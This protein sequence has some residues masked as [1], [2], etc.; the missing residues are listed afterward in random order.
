VETSL[1]ISRVFSEIGFFDHTGYQPRTLGA[2]ADAAV[3]GFEERMGGLIEFSKR[4]AERLYPYITRGDRPRAEPIVLEAANESAR[5][6]ADLL[7]TLLALAQAPKVGRPDF[8]SLAVSVSSTVVN[9]MET[10]PAKLILANTTYST[11]SELVML[12]KGTYRG[13]FLMRNLP[14][15]TYRAMVS[16]WAPGRSLWMP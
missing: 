7:H 16:G 12:D 4:R 13:V 6:T 9:G 1:T 15:G 5:V 2:D 14:P 3:R 11:T 10:L 8:G